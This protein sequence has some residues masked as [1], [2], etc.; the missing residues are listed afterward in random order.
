MARRVT[1]V[2]GGGNLVPHVASAIR[3]RGDVLQVIDLVGRPEI[4]ADQVLR[5]R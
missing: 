4:A 5:E 1:L 3:E 2:A